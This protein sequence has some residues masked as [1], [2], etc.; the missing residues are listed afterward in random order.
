GRVRADAPVL[1]QQRRED[2]AQVGV[3]VAFRHAPQMLLTECPHAIRNRVV[4][5]ARLL[6]RNRGAVCVR[7]SYATQ[8]RRDLVVQRL[9][10]FTRLLRQRDAEIAQ[11][12]VTLE[13]AGNAVADRLVLVRDAELLA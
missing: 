13:D 6:F 12:D 8:V 5:S 4:R 1:R 11:A 2:Q 7:L 9:Q 3:D 10:L